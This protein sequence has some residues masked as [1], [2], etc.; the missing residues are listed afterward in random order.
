MFIY[1]SLLYLLVCSDQDG[2]SCLRPS[3]LWVSVCFSFLFF[4]LLFL[5]LYVLL[6]IQCVAWWTFISMD[7]FHLTSVEAVVKNICLSLI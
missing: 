4:S 1:F 6:V 7:L 3:F 5:K 2:F